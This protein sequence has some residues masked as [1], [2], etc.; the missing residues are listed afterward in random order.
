MYVILGDEAHPL[1][2]YLMR[3]FPRQ[4]L[5][6]KK[7]MFNYRLSRA[8]RCIECTFGILRSKW[9]FLLTEL[10]A[11]V[12]KSESIAKY[13]CLLH[14]IIIEEE[15]LQIEGFTENMRL[16]E[17]NNILGRQRANRGTNLSIRT[18]NAFMAFL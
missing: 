17:A 13:A 4:N 7:K 11:N 10:E 15:G 12:E 3:P 5:I 8:R 18:R 16:V 1:K 14:N 6:F 9:R 2:I